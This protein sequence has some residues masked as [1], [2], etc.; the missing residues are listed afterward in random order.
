MKDDYDARADAIRAYN[1]P[2][3]EGFETRLKQAG[4]SPKTVKNQVSDID[5]FGEY[6]VYYDDPLKRLDEADEGDVYRF[7]ADWFPRK[8]M[9]SSESSVKAYLTSF[10][11]FFS[12]L[13]QTGQVSDQAVSRVL[14]T[15]KEERETFLE[16]VAE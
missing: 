15:L 14:S 12:W 2:I 9:W 10:R 16:A 13:G 5:F 7:L 4:L 8:A 6:L 1:Q 3:L 11:K